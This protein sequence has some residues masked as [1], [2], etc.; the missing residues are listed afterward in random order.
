MVERRKRLRLALEARDPIAVRGERVREDLQG[1][2]A[3][4]RRVA[5]AI[6]LAHAAFAERFTDFAGTNPGAGFEVHQVGAIIAGA[7]R[8]TD[9]PAI[10]DMFPIVFCLTSFTSAGSSRPTCDPWVRPCPRSTV[11]RR[12]SRDRRRA[13]ASPCESGSRPA[14]LGSE[15]NDSRPSGRGSMGCG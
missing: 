4:K 9:H 14:V 13:N 7:S 12:M 10:H 6:H 3:A 8:R 2:V 15:T 1:D 11:R 5:R